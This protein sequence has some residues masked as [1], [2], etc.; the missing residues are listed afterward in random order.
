M[1]YPLPPRASR[2][3]RRGLS[4][5]LSSLASALVFVAVF[6]TT[7]VGCVVPQQEPEPTACAAEANE[8]NESHESAQDLGELRDDPDS[9]RS[10]TSSVHNTRDQ[11]WYRVHVSDRGLGG[12]PVIRVLVS[13][14]FE[15]ATWFVCDEGRS[16]SSE[17]LDD[18]SRPFE[19]VNYVD[20]C[21]GK[22]V[23]GETTPSGTTEPSPGV[24]ASSTTDCSGTSSDDGILYVRVEHTGPAGSGC[25]YDLTIDV[26]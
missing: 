17:C 8:P 1:A 2:P 16:A 9:K 21:Q 12:D 23:D 22:A 6:V 24:M 18:G 3:A 10:I 19:T 11:D 15:V 4:L 13:S 14:G 7:S 5:L 25:T 26:Q 20:G